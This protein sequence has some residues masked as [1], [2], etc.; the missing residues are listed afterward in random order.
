MTLDSNALRTTMRHWVTGVTIVTTMAGEERAG[1]T[2][3]SFTSVSLDP[4]TVL[5]CL[6]KE[7][8]AHTLVMKSSVYAISLLGIGQEALSNRFAGL[9]PAVTDRFEG[10]DCPTADTGSPLIPSAIG[11]L[12]CRVKAAHDA[13]THT[14]F[15]A[16][17]VHARLNEERPPLVY[18]NRKY[19]LLVA[20]EDSKA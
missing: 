2:V 15:V 20:V 6:N 1:M 17:V 4:P 18:F 12:D 16:E 3:S 14:I 7:T 10:L 9:D 11:W 13:F 8:Y 5:V 19:Q